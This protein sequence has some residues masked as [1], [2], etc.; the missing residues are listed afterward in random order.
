MEHPTLKL[1]AALALVA[2]CG[3]EPSQDLP[4][5]SPSPA[6]SA[7]APEEKVADDRPK[8]VD[9]SMPVR[10]RQSAVGKAYFNSRERVENYTFDNAIT[11]YQAEHGEY[12]KSHEEFMEKLWKPLKAPMPEIEP[13]YRYEYDPSDHKVYKVLIED[14]G[15]PSTE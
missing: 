4:A 9:A 1:V 11:L 3:C 8:R 7:P 6:A 5:S 14:E 10:Q 2:A 12:P 13:G 15:E